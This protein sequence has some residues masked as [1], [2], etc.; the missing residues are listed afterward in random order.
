MAF[1]NKL[2]RAGENP[3]RVAKQLREKLSHNAVM[4]QIPIGAEDRFEG[5]VDLVYMLA[6]Y[7]RGDDGKDV[8]EAPIPDD[9]LA[10]AQEY[11]EILLDAA[12][13]FSDQL[14]EEMLEENVQPLTIKAAVRKAC[15]LRQLTPVFMGSVYK[16]KGVQKLLDGVC[17]YL[18]SP[19]E[20][21]NIALDQDMDEK[22]VN[23]VPDP[24]KPFIA[25]AFKLTESQYG[26][27]TYLRLYEGTLRKGD[28][29]HNS[30]SKHKVK[31]GRLVRMHSDS[32]E[33]I[34]VAYGGDIVALF[35]VD[36]R[37]G[38][39][40]TDGTVNWTMTS[41]FV[42]DP[43][44]HYTIKPKA[45]QTG[46]N[47]S[48]SLARFSK[49]D[50]TFRVGSD[51]ESGETIISGMGELHL[52]VYIERMKREYNTPVDVSPPRV[53]YRETITRKSEYNYTHKKQT[54]GSGQYG[55][56]GGYIE[57]SDKPQFEFVDK[58]SGGVV[59]RE[60]IAAVEK[61]FRSL[62]H[63][64]LLIGVPVTNVRVILDDGGFHAVDS[65]DIAFQE[66][67]RGAWRSVYHSANPIILEPIMKVEL[68][69]PAEFHGSMVGTILQRRGIIV[70]STEDDGF[71]RVEAEV[72][73]AEMFGYST[74]LR[75]ATQG[76]AE[77]SMEFAKYEKAPNSVSEELIKKYEQERKDAQK[78]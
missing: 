27:L 73:L 43:V 75:S 52:D 5:V 31:V 38:D 56:V 32:M 13:M 74:A 58:V 1:I 49:E 11:R 25:L 65:S 30:N 71:S 72:P 78:K 22:P 68:E 69:G 12:S 23:V 20:V 62:Q 17:D 46:N 15:I 18:P 61:G 67:A 16:N 53:A 41:I 3:Y 34:D 42:P 59:P 39:T 76:K 28:F 54:G 44:I 19:P 7:F 48:K 60:F 35:G 64:G 57:P 14:T 63:K 77:F 37:S 47:F 66:A 4:M 6:Y 21:E 40:F 9:M 55:K 8:I 50:P 2:D 51:P 70:G 36:C 26:Q 10:Q 33:D 29:I 24:K 45:G